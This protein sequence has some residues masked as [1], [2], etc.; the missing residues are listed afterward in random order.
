MATWFWCIAVVWFAVMTVRSA[1]NESWFWFAGWLLVLLGA[2]AVLVA[3]LTRNRQ[4]GR[5]DGP[6]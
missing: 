3:Q 6:R 4:A 1:V 2:I 5:S